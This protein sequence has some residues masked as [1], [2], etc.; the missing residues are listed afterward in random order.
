VLREVT[1]L[2]VAHRPSTVQLA[3]R[4]AML[5]G[6]KIVAVGTHSHL[7]ANTPGYRA[8]LS[9]LDNERDEVSA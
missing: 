9:S 4:V 2:V 7:L 6:G 1:A 3:D 8:L 5:T